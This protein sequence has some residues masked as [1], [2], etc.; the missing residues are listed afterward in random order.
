MPLPFIHINNLI[1]RTL[2]K[3]NRILPDKLYLTLLYRLTF[4]KV[5]SWSKPLTFNEKLNWLKINFKDEKCIRVVDKST[6]KGYVSS[7]IGNEY[8][9]PTYKEWD[10]PNDISLDELP[11]RF[12]L[13]TNHDSGTVIVCNNK[14]TLDLEAVKISLQKAL[15]TDFSRTFREWPYQF[16]RRKI[17]AEQFLE[18]DNQGD[19]RDYKFF[20]F[21]GEPKFLKVDFNRNV[22]HRAN[23][24][25]L[26]WQLLSFGE[27]ICP[28]DYNCIIQQPKNFDL[29]VVLARKL[30]LGFPFVRI[31]FYN[32]DG[33][34]YFGEMTLFP[35]AGFGRFI[36]DS[37]D[38]EIGHLLDLSIDNG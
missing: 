24:Y 7:V 13:K 6:V 38:L 25:S 34:I 22:K 35:A 17:I 30:S 32:I 31:D 33:K 3:Y 15:N 18:A 5:I 26:T 8:I 11:E 12:V 1:S 16:V 10:N 29:M 27:A 37:A 21:N 4:K 20:C 9:I 2:K 28:P 36:P 23:Y 19:L 14:K